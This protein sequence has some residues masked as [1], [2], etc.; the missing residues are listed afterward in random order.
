MR[1]T[2]IV[3]TVLLTGC[4]SSGSMT[5]AERAK[6][7]ARADLQ[8]ACRMWAIDHHMEPE[9]FVDACHRWAWRKTL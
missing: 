1:A 4:V 9:H 2:L 5:H 6:A 7:E 8:H 3:M